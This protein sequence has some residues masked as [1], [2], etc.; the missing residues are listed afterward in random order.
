MVFAIIRWH[1]LDLIFNSIP[2]GVR[3][4]YAGQLIHYPNNTNDSPVRNYNPE[5]PDVCVV[6]HYPHHPR[7]KTNQINYK[8]I[9]SHIYKAI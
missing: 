9:K 2:Q 1:L 8:M 3:S 7:H 6:S 4:H 5:S